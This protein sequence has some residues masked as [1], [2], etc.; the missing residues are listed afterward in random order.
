MK[1]LPGMLMA[2]R[3]LGGIADGALLA[4]VGSLLLSF[5]FRRRASVVLGCDETVPV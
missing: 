4:S 2:D 3:L 1:Y 5:V